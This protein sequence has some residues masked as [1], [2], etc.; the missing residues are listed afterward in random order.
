MAHAPLATDA[1]RAIRDRDSEVFVSAASICE[2]EVKA[3]VGKL[4]I[5]GDL[6]EAARLSGF[7][8]LPITF[9]HGTE[10]GRLPL[11]HSDPFDRMLVAQARA[12]GLTLVTRDASF[13]AYG[14]PLLTA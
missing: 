3:T 2:A 13:R 1:Q 5:S 10:A 9:L 11:H 4:T 8:E 12:E 6:V 7:A 14:V